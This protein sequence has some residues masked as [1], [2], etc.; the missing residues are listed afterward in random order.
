MGCSH[1]YN[2]QG[3]GVQYRLTQ[4]ENP[5]IRGKNPFMS[6][7]DARRVGETIR[8]LFFDAKMRL[9]KRVVIHKRTQFL[10]EEREGLMAGLDGVDNIDMLELVEDPVL[11]FV[12]T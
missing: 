1:I 12:L 4:I 2:S 9:P 8:Q 10:R 11:R 7:D 6:R 3:E 5:V